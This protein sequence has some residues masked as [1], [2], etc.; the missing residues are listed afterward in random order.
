MR[1]RF[2]DEEPPPE[3][4]AVDWD[5]V[6]AKAG[7]EIPTAGTDTLCWTVLGCRS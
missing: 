6:K 3:A 5:A 1:H 4:K 2:L 7:K